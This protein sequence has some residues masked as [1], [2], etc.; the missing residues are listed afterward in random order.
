MISGRSAV[1]LAGVTAQMER[2]HAA[3]NEIKMELAAD[4][5]SNQNAIYLSRRA[6]RYSTVLSA[7]LRNL[8][9]SLLP[10]PVVLTIDAPPAS[11]PPKPDLKVIK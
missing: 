8:H 9:E 3:I 1:A 5:E 10:D 2:V 11:P 6:R 4:R 7:R